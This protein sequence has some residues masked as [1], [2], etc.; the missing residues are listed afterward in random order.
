[1]YKVDSMGYFGGVSKVSRGPWFREWY[2]E[3]DGLE[4]FYTFYD[5]DGSK[6]HLLSNNMTC[7]DREAFSSV[8]KEHVRAN[9]MGWFA[10]AYL[11]FETIAHT[12]SLKALAPGYKFLTM[13]GLGFVYKSCI[14]YYFSYYT[15]PVMGAFLRK[16]TAAAKH[17]AFDIKDP[18]REYFYIDTSE[19]MNYSNK[20]LGDQYHCSHGPQPEGEAAD[21]SYLVEVDKFLRGEPNHLKDHPKFLN[22]P[23]EF[24]DKSFP[25]ADAV[26]DMM[27]KKD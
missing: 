12:P 23:F 8:Y 4:Y 25:T 27:S 19:Y 9:R 10:G 21:S 26:K 13:L 18:K 2:V 14:N 24:I 3:D 15:N 5:H 1:M 17:D 7:K 11:G 22:Y 16:Y 20:S 6:M